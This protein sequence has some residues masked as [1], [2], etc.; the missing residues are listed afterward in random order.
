MTCTDQLYE[1]LT[2]WGAKPSEAIRRML[3]DEEIFLRLLFDFADSKDWYDLNNLLSLGEYKDAFV[4]SHRMKGSCADLALIPLYDCL[5]AVTDDLRGGVHV[6]LDKD[7]EE[8]MCTR[9]SLIELL[10][11]NKNNI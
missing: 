11:A 2:M 10:E 4:I 8:L 5:S 6:T 1:D 9:E 7:Y 3:G